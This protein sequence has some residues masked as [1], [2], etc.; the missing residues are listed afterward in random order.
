MRKGGLHACL[1]AMG[2]GLSSST[3]PGEGGA[4][5]GCG[6]TWGSLGT[7]EALLWACQAVEWHP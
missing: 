1:E 2:A 5:A 4:E 3:F 7:C 6:W